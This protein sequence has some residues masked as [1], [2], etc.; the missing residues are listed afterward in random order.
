MKTTENNKLIT[1]AEYM[2]NS[3]ELHHAYYLQF[4]TVETKKYI[5]ASLKIDDI[6]KALDAGDVH[7]NDIEIPYN[8]MS[9]GGKWWWDDAPINTI[10]LKESGGCN[11]LSTH[12]CVAKAMAEELAKENIK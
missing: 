6:K 11:S 8:N 9:R 5:L 12:T 1:Y 7:L 4:A 2:Q 10:L 3:S